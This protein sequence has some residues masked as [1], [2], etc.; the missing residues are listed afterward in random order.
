MDQKRNINY[1]VEGET[2]VKRHW[3][4]GLYGSRSGNWQRQ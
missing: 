4:G 1:R 2:E 3:A